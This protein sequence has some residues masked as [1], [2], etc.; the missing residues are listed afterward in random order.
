MD[1]QNFINNNIDYLS[2]FRKLNLNVKTYSQL[3]LAI[4]T[5]KRNVDYNFNEIIFMKWCKGAI[6]NTETNKVV[7]LPPQKCLE[8]Y[9]FS[10]VLI[11]NKDN[12]ILQPLIDGTM[13]NMFYHKD[14]WLISTRSFIGGKNKWD[15]ELSFKKMFDECKEKINMEELNK[16]NSYSFVLQHKENRIISE[17]VENNIIL[18]EEYSFVNNIPNVVDFQGKYETIMSIKNN[19]MNVLN[20]SMGKTFNFQFK[21][22]TLKNNEKRIN[23]INNEYQRAHDIKMECNYNNKLLS[24]IYLRNNNL[25]KDYLA[26]FNDDGLLFDK[27]RNIIYIMKN[28]LY[29][30]YVKF[31]IKKVIEKKQIPFQLKP[32]VYDLHTIYKQDKKKITNEIINN[33]IYNMP[34]K[35]LCFVLNYYIT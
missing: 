20:E 24:Y 19:D 5:Y 32:L 11:E 33:Y 21:G 35:K 29:D 27:Y 4:I 13:I 31:F 10:D 6:I 9:T 30:C 14:E 15:Q 16:N 25:L 23:I 2:Q 18:V 26:Y 34:D 8:K 12:F 7:C 22:F 3:N 28:E 1:L 17:I